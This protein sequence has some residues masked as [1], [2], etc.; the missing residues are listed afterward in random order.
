[1][2][3]KF[4]PIL[5]AVRERYPGFMVKTSELVERFSAASQRYEITLKSLEARRQRMPQ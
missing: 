2:L 5:E 4:A 3:A 1:L